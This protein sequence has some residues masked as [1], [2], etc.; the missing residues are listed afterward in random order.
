[1]K[2]SVQ[3]ISSIR[4]EMDMNKLQNDLFAVGEWC[5]TW[6]MMLNVEKYKV[7]NFDKSNPKEVYCMT[8]SAC[9]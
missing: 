7:M 9:N 8:N 4:E 3:I 5:R 6:G 1:M 2:F